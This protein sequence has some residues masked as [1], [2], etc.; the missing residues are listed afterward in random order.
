[1]T[2]NQ[3]IPLILYF[4]FFFTNMG[5]QLAR[6]HF[7]GDPP[8]SPQPGPNAFIFNNA[9]DTARITKATCTYYAAPWNIY[10]FN[11]SLSFYIYPDL[12]KFVNV[13]PIYKDGCPC[14]PSNYM[15]ISKLDCLNTMF[16]E[17]EAV[18]MNLFVSKYN[19]LPPKQHGFTQHVFL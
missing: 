8:F 3:Q 10:I 2:L 4:C 9:S 5:P 16:E 11:H 19:M 13:V 6:A 15:P 1:M 14:E 12:L 17:E 18:R 7:D